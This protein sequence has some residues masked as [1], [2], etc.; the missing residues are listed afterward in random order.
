MLALFL[1]VPARFLLSL[2]SHADP[3]KRNEPMELVLTCWHKLFPCCMWCTEIRVLLPS[4]CVLFLW[5]FFLRSKF[6]SDFLPSTPKKAKSGT[7]STGGSPRTFCSATRTV[8]DTKYHSFLSDLSTEQN[9]LYTPTTC[10]VYGTFW[11]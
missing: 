3:C 5:C 10:A 4:H 9:F 8:E 7:K 6:Q 2:K 1:L 11:A